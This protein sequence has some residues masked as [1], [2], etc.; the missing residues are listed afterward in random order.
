[1]PAPETN[2]SQSSQAPVNPFIQNCGAIGFLFAK[3]LARLLPQ[4]ARYGLARFTARV[5][6][7]LFKKTKLE[8][9]ANLKKLLGPNVPDL[10]EKT[11]ELFENFFLTMCD[12]MN[13]RGVTYEVEGLGELRQ[14]VSKDEGVLFI[15]FHLGHWDLGARILCEK[16]WSLTAIYQSYA[17]AFL[18][19]VVHAGRPQALRYLPVGQGAAFGAISALSKGE[20]VAVIGDKPFGEPGEPVPLLGGTVLWPKGPYVLGARA[21]AWV[22]PGL[23][24]RTAPGRY[25]GFL[26]KP[27]RVP[28]GP[29]ARVAAEL[30]ARVAEH[31]ADYLRTY[32]TQWYRFERFW[33][34]TGH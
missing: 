16:G 33:I 15:T 22:V 9:Q 3:C 17:S 29:T 20:G 32:P 8:V 5:S 21:A 13:P 24:V 26:E 31:F 6:A 2:A 28:K 12:F 34:E 19:K 7:R 23:V 30:S 14:A 1:M 4:K 11:D 25:R 27:I 18:Q 10:E